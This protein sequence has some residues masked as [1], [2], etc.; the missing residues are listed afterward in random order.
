LS[1]IINGISGWN[2]RCFCCLAKTK[3]ERCEVGAAG[4]D[5]RD[6]RSSLRE[7]VH[8]HGRVRSVDGIGD[9]FKTD[10]IIDN[11]S[12]NGLYLRI[13]WNIKQGSQTCIA[14]PL[15]TDLADVSHKMAV[16]TRGVALRS[17]PKSDGSW[18]VAVAFA[19]Y[20]VL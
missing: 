10:V 4:S 16:T 3:G 5:M 12:V 2:L 9:T 19:R 11:L 14:L 6:I 20:R 7:I 1:A 15:S 18:G 13:P 8:Y 17:E